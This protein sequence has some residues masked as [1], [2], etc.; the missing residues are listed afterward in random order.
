MLWLSICIHSYKI[1]ILICLSKRVIF[2][3][4]EMCVLSFQETTLENLYIKELVVDIHKFKN[5]D[6]SST[7]D[8]LF[9][10]VF[11]IDYIVCNVE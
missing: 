1:E 9:P 7:A 8:I 2:R 4:S 10:W 11:G 6:K 3:K 5:L